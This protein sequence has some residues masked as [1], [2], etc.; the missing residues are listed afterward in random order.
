MK[1]MDNGF[2]SFRKSMILLKEI[3]EIDDSEYEFLIKDIILN[4]HHS[5]ETLF[6]Y[7]IYNI[8]MDLLLNDITVR[9][10]YNLKIERKLKEKATINSIDSTI[11]CIE[12]VNMVLSLRNIDLSSWDYELFKYLKDY[13]NAITHYEIDLNN[14]II[15]HLIARLL[16][17]LYKIFLKEIPE[18]KEYSKRNRIDSNIEEVIKEHNEWFLR[19]LLNY[20][21]KME[22]S[23]KRIAFLE[24]NRKEIGIIFDKIKES[25]IQHEK[26]PI[27]EKSAFLRTGTVILGNE[28][29]FFFG[30]CKYCSIDL[31]KED[32]R[33]I[34]YSIKDYKYY[35]KLILVHLEILLKCPSL[36]S[37]ELN[38]DDINIL[39]KYYLL[40]EEGAIRITDKIISVLME[41]LLSKEIYDYC[42][43]KVNYNEKY[44][45]KV[46]YEGF[47]N[48]DIED[49]L[50]TLSQDNFQILFPIIDNFNT[51]SKGS[52]YKLK[53]N[54]IAQDDLDC[55]LEYPGS[56]EDEYIT[57][58]NIILHYDLRPDFIDK[59]TY[60]LDRSV[61]D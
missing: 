12:A 15:E 7:I 34:Y 13:R 33:F 1:L 30:H 61:V 27:C 44:A 47:Q 39:N 45:Y 38:D 36:L 50:E 26:C 54:Y 5:I 48:L 11:S 24:N 18:F 3:E 29:K 25:K 9:D 28:E 21:N 2:D 23:D 46:L 32:A 31:S 59:L 41:D 42:D 16:P 43:S 14:E 35:N 4:L 53:H 6:K 49:K 20:L 57:D 17:L 58:C 22:T 60:K 56:S 51:L 40:N 8:D 55:M 37:N 19:M 52:F 10:F